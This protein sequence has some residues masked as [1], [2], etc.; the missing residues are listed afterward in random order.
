MANKTINIKLSGKDFLSTDQVRT[1]M[2]EINHQLGDGV[3]IIIPIPWY[4][5]LFKWI[6]KKIK[7]CKSYE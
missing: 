2:S 6:A 4:K 1:L 7:G 5:R 3:E